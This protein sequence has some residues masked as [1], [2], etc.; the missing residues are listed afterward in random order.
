MKKIVGRNL[1]ILFFILIFPWVVNNSNSNQSIS[2]ISLNTVGN[3]Q[4][5]TCSYSFFEFLRNNFFNDFEVHFDK[6]SSMKCFGKINGADIVNDKIFVYLGTNLNLDLLIQASF[7]LFL[8]S[9]I[10]KAN[11]EFKLKYPLL[12]NLLVTLLVILHFFGEPEFYQLNSKMFTL[13][14]NNNYLFYSLLISFFLCFKIFTEIISTRVHNI[15]NFFP[16][17][18]LIVGSFNSV[19]LNLFLLLISF[20]GINKFIEKRQY[21][22]FF[23]ILMLLNFFWITQINFEYS[24]FDIDKLTGFSSSSYNPLSTTFWVIIYFFLVLGFY[25]IILFSKP[26]F[27]ILK[28]QTNLLITGSLVFI[29]SIIS[30]SHPVLN[31]ITYYYLGLNK[32]GS[33]TLSSVQENAWRGISSSAESIG[34]FYGLVIFFTIY[35]FFIIKKQKISLIQ[36]FMLIL[37]MFGL[38]RS[39]NFSVFVLLIIFISVSFVATRII[40]KRKVIVLILVI[41]SLFPLIYLQFF[42]TYNL[43]NASRQVIDVGLEISYIENLDTNEWGLTAIDQKRYLELLQ[44]EEESQSISTSLSY[45]INK[46]HF[47]SRNFIPNITTLISSVASPINR[48]VKWG[49]FFGKYNPNI[50]TF[51]FGT[52]LNNLSNYYL[53]HNTRVNDGLVLPHS[54]IFSYLIFI[55]AFGLFVL[56]SF[57]I[58]K[59]WSNKNNLF[60]ILLFLYMFINSMKNDNVLYLNSFLL[61]ILIL[62]I[63]KLIDKEINE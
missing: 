11:D 48:G 61:I 6:S 28:F 21:L 55:G 4:S 14:L 56:I 15:I 32:T 23:I 41:C 51:W 18:F 50:Y 3:Y 29:F 5:N 24:F 45:L 57:F 49:V 53:Q 44:S 25:E 10:P 62:N 42:N 34:E 52:G 19:N 20:I 58:Y 31:F 26:Y 17:L 30:A 7:W 35:L 1:L 27:D 9:L 37:N 59:V 54:S 39:N 63:D 8:L 33:K 36:L 12:S 43:E 47:S 2:E 16:F 40:D 13:D 22:M 46:Y 60:N 38:V